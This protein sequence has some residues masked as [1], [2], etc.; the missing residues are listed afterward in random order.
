[1]CGNVSLSVIVS[2]CV[3]ALVYICCM[4]DCEYSYVSLYVIVCGE[5]MYV[6]VS[7]PV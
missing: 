7:A 3:C 2:I 5:C 4:S 1:M 6:S